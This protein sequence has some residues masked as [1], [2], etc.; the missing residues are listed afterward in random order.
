MKACKILKDFKCGHMQEFHFQTT[1]IV[2]MKHLFA[3]LS[4][5]KEGRNQSQ[6]TDFIYSKVPFLG[7][8]PLKAGIP[9]FQAVCF[10]GTHHIDLLVKW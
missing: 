10:K 6:K 7:F 5:D 9:H 2:L 4:Q 1:Q 8:K 3:N